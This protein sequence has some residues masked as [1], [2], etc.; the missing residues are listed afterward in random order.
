MRP[1]VERLQGAARAAQTRARDQ[2][3]RLRWAGA[4]AGSY[5]LDT[6]FLALFAAD[7]VI[8]AA[9][10]VVYGLGAAAVC[11]AVWATT[12][13]GANLRLRDP[14]L[15]APLIGAA[16]ALQIAAVALAPPIAFPFLSNLF[17]VF[18][19]GMLWMGPRQ[20][21]L[22]WS[23]GALALGGLFAAVGDGF[24]VP[25]ATPYQRTLVWLYFSLILGRCVLL[26]VQAS[27]LRRRLA[28]GRFRLAESL[29]QMRQLASHDELTLSLNRRS[30]MARLEQ[31]RSRVERGGEGFSV[32]LFDL[33]HFK[34]VNDTHGHAVGDDV[35]RAFAR[36]AHGAMRDSDAF[37][38]YGGEEFMLILGGTAPVAALAAVER[39]RAAFAGRDWSELA[40]GLRVTVSAGVAGYRR[41]EKSSQL[42]N[43]ADGALYEA[44][45]AGRDRAIVKE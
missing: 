10:P 45:R 19:F 9:A 6:L 37:G 12:A 7:G 30:L 8:G 27:D 34:Q 36:T 31:E 42:L 38:R 2:R 32:A 1:E 26:S 39:V 28:E 22:V 4:T 23:L 33:D 25:V 24:G 11:L 35:L 41:G 20:S 14:N 40:P 17:T 43:R 16:V 5:A 3:A 21:M 15:S 29:E 18:A 13:A 44:K